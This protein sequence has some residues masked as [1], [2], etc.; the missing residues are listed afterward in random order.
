MTGFGRGGSATAVWVA[1]VEIGT[2]NRKQAEVVVILPKELTEI[3][4]TIRKQVQGV[5]SRGRA[6]VVVALE[7]AGGGTANVRVDAGLARGLEGAFAQLSEAVGR[8]V[9]PGA[10][11]FLRQPGVLTIGAREIDPAEAWTA[12]GPALEEALGQLAAMR[13]REGADLE[14]DLAGRLDLLEKLVSGMAGLAPVRLVRQRELLFKRLRDAGL[15]LDLSDERVVKELALFADRC[16]V[17]EELTRLASH[18]GKFRDYMAGTEPPGR[19]LDFLCQ[20]IFREFN[21]IGAKANDAGIAQTVVEAKTEL[22]KIRE[23]VQNVE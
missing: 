21:T 10:G 11:D 19:A 16:E 9:L 14:A 3:E 2:V 13:E 4:G 5:V 23:Q 1:R 12:I 18:F 15:E 22:E 6:Q 17:S 20:E 8:Q 7:P